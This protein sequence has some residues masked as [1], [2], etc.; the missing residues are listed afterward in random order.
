M[1][2][3]IGGWL[4]A[5]AVLTAA[6]GGAEFSRSLPPGDFREAGLAKLSEAELA[7]LDE[8]V[9]AFHAG[10]KAAPR[11]SVRLPADSATASFPEAP[12]RGASVV[13]AAGTKVELAAVRSRLKGKFTGWEPRGVFA[14]EN[15]QRWREA[16]GTTYAMPPLDAP[17]VRISPGAL[18]SFWMEIEGVRTRVKVVRVDT[19]D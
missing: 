6:A 7:R 13:V 10:G 14:L 3:I 17:E 11:P 2:L 15:G 18:G 16:N 19:G 4:G 1:R 9:N 12:A 8:L 5:A